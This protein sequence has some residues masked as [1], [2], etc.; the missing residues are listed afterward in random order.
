VLAATNTDLKAPASSTLALIN[1][2]VTSFPLILPENEVARGAA[3]QKLAAQ[4]SCHV[5]ND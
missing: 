5:S 3:R 2:V 4:S 1:I